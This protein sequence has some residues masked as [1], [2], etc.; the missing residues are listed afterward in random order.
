MLLSYQRLC[1]ASITNYQRDDMGKSIQL[2]LD[3]LLELSSRVVAESRGKITGAEALKD[4]VVKFQASVGYQFL[5]ELQRSVDLETVHQGG[6]P[7][8][9]GPFPGKDQ[10]TTFVAIYTALKDA[11]GHLAR[12]RVL[13]RTR[14][15]IIVA[16]EAAELLLSL[17]LS[18]AKSVHQLAKNLGTIL[19]N[20]DEFERVSGSKGVYRHTAFPPRDVSLLTCEDLEIGVDV[21]D[22]ASGNGLGVDDRMLAS[23]N[24]EGSAEGMTTP[25]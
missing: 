18:D 8:D 16:R 1:E 17:G 12:M 13:A 22:V 14:D 6:I 23:V 25:I 24:G 19:G 21:L 10:F 15:G 3:E 20:S 4:A 2:N 9:L 5:A 11:D 7:D